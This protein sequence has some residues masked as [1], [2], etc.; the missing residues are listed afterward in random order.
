MEQITVIVSD[1]NTPVPAPVVAVDI[2][3]SE[4]LERISETGE[5]NAAQLAM[6]E[7]HLNDATMEG[8]AGVPFRV[9]V[10]NFPAQNQ[11]IYPYTVHRGVDGTGVIWDMI[12]YHSAIPVI[13]YVND[14]GQKTGTRPAGFVFANMGGA[15]VAPFLDIKIQNLPSA[16]SVAAGG[17]YK[18]V[19]VVLTN[20]GNVD[21]NGF[22]GR[23]AKNSQLITS[24]KTEPQIIFE[25]VTYRNDYNIFAFTPA[26]SNIAYTTNA[27]LKPGESK[28]IFIEYGATPTA[29]PQAM[30]LTNVVYNL[31]GE[32]NT[33][34]NS[35]NIAVTITPMESIVYNMKIEAPDI[36]QMN[37]APYDDPRTFLI[38]I[39]N[40]GTGPV[41][42]Y[43]AHISYNPDLVNVYPNN[44]PQVDYNGEIIDNNIGDFQVT[45]SAGAMILDPNG[46]IAP[47]QTKKIIFN[48]EPSQITQSGQ[49]D[50]VRLHVSLPNGLVDA[51]TSDNEYSFDIEI[52]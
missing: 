44:N 1:D 47:N 34:N 14:T 38:E 3:A 17:A 28:F 36:G 41:T 30:S 7:Q 18:T 5:L 20:A 39:T 48:I 33:T 49:F 29:T 8:A 13:Y 25:G 32:N 27:I 6:V 50:N 11:I 21:I 51:D 4:I 9:R 15:P 22:S 43:S 24:L 52:T 23:L 40:K 31:S 16:I 10:D 19:L 12:I 26:S 35:A 37:F 46:S 42:G 2:V 45:P